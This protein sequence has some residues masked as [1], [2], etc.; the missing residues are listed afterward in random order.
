MPLQMMVAI[1]CVS[2]GHAYPEEARDVN[3][4][5]CGQVIGQATSVRRTKDVVLGMVEEYI[6]ATER[7]AARQRG[8]DRLSASALET[9]K[10]RCALGYTGFV[11]H[12]RRPKVAGM[13]L[14]EALYTTRAMR[15][16]RKD[17]IPLDVQARILDA[18][19]RAPS[20]G[21]QQNWRFL[22]LDDPEKKAALAPLYQH[23][24]SE[25]WRVVY[26]PQL[27]AAAANPEAPESI[28]ILKVQRSAQWL[29]D[30]FEDV[31]LYLFPFSQHD[32]TGGSIYPAVWSAMLAAR[33]EGVGSCLTALLQFFHPGRDVRDPRRAHRR[34]LD[35]LGHRQLRLPD[36][37]VGRRSPPPGPRSHVPQQLGV[38]RRLHGP[39]SSMAG[40]SVVAA[41]FGG[42]V[43]R[44]AVAPGEPV[45]AGAVLLVIESMKM[46]HVIEAPA[47]GTVESFSVSVG[48]AVQQGDVLLTFAPSAVHEER[49]TANATSTASAATRD[50]I[51]PEL[52]E[53]RRRVGSHT[54][55]RPTRGDRTPARS[56][57]TDGSGEHRG[58]LRL[59]QLRGIRT[60]RHRGPAGATQ[61]A[62]T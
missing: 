34:G 46:E 14:H 3:F 15:R 20:G 9:T 41:A 22:L 60:L 37:H 18:A 26:K 43:L 53:L 62:T 50:D 45:P 49:P 21:N 61:H 38:R 39:R 27:D 7:A 44:L 51:R 57:A 58:S 4:N 23:A 33:A 19:I 28:Q 56:R 55:R 30:H 36:R 47:T 8:R 52:A 6:E 48:D 1:D 32:P 11:S 25:L 24:I 5:P 29:A 17:P 31:P 12:V 54:G 13:E 42:T 2:R 40:V 10:R 59:R 16:V 35:P